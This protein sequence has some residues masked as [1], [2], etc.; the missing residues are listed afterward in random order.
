MRGIGQEQLAAGIGSTPVARLRALVG[1]LA[2]ESGAG[3]SATERLE[4]LTAAEEVKAALAALQ[5]RVTVAFVDA[6]DAAREVKVSAAAPGFEK[7]QAQRLAARAA[8]SDRSEVAIARRENPSRGDR[9]VGMAK[10]LMAELP[11][12]MMLL[13]CGAIAEEVALAVVAGTA[14]LTRTDRA[15]ADARLVG[16][17]PGM[18]GKQARRAADRVTAALD[19]AAVVAAHDRAVAS[20]RVTVRPAPAGMAYLTVLGPLAQAV[21]AYAALTRDADTALPGGDGTTSMPGRGRGQVMADLALQ[22]LTGLAPGEPVPMEIGLVMPAGALLNPDTLSAAASTSP[23]PLGTAGATRGGFD[24]GPDQTRAEAGAPDL[25]EPWLAEGDA[26]AEIVGYGPVPSALVRRWIRHGTEHGPGEPEAAARVWLRRLYTSPDGRDLVAMDSRRRCFT[27][28]LRT[29]V[30]LRDGHQCR[31]PFCD[32]PARH[33]DHAVPAEHGGPTTA[34]NGAAGCARHNYDKQAHGWA[35]DVTDT[36]LDG[37]GPHAI[38]YR[39]PNRQT[40]TSRAAPL[41]GVGSH[42]PDHTVGHGHDDAIILLALAGWTDETTAWDRFRQQLHE[43]IPLDRREQACYDLLTTDR[44]PHP[45]D[46]LWPDSETADHAR[47]A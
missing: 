34:G 10:A 28:G 11:A 38:T 29:F 23:T 26:T 41:N 12:T 15:T 33:L 17:L 6:R 35:A 9:H 42:H 30:L 4:V 37:T 32:A 47:A 14:T 46:D 5:A 20:R 25:D 36:G 16:D 7:A 31:L 45:W 43:G 40:H 2:A 24:P 22:R 27:G 3:S 19:A 13:T 8:S 39:T 21:S 18:T 44:E 1:E